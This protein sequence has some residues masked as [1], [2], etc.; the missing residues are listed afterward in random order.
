MVKNIIKRF[1]SKNPKLESD[2]S[3]ISL[4]VKITK[5]QEAYI[6]A[7]LDAV[8]EEESMQTFK[9]HGN[10][11]DL[12]FGDSDTSHILYFGILDLPILMEPNTNG[13]TAKRVYIDRIEG[14]NEVNAFSE[15]E[16]LFQ[17]PNPMRNEK[18]FNQDGISFSWRQFAKVYIPKD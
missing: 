6:K 12:E 16:F 3:D 4:P 10:H 17:Y 13:W 7:L 5:N 11:V 18:P 9:K 1:F 2:K 8:L 14:D 15:M